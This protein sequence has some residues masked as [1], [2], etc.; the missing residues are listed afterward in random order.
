MGHTAR[1]VRKEFAEFFASPAAL[2]FLGA[3]LVIALFLFFWVE[4][5]FARNIADARALFK[6]L[7]VLLIFLAATLTM[8]T[9]SEERRAGTIETLLTSPVPRVQLVL[10]KFLAGVALVALAL[11]LTF[12]LPV[13][14][15]LLGPLDWGPVIGGYVAALFLAA[16]YIAIGVYMS[17][18]TDNPIVA[19]ILTTMVC[20]VF[21]LLGSPTITGF[22]GHE[23]GGWLMLIGSGARFESV[24]RGVLDL[25]DLY[26]YC[27]I[28][29]MFLT[30]N[31]FSLERVAWAG[32][33][34]SR[35][36]AHWWLVV[37]LVLA[38]FIAANFWLQSIS[39]VRLDITRD[40]MYSLSEATDRYLGQLEEPLLIRGY[41]SAKT[42]PLLAPMVPAIRD[43]LEEYAQI[44]GGNVQVEFVDPHENQALEEEAA[45]KYDIRP[46]PF[47]M[48]SRHQS[49]VVNSYFHVVVAYGDQNETLSFRNLIDVKG[50]SNGELDVVLKDPE[51]AITSAIKKVLT[52]YRAGGNPFDTLTGDV[53]F[54][55]YLSAAD[56]LPPELA[57]LRGDLE[58]VLGELEK[59]SDGRFSVSIVDPDSNGGAL[60]KKLTERYGLRPQLSGLSDQQRFWFSMLMERGGE[61][62]QVPL[63]EDL[64]RESIKRTLV[65]SLK[66]LVPGFLKTIALVTPPAGP[67]ADPYQYLGNALMEN[68]RMTNTDL[69]TGRVPEEVDLLMV[70][71]PGNLNDKQVFAI[72]QFLMQGGT[73][74]LATS[75]NMVQIGADLQVQ[76][77]RSGLEEWL[78]YQGLS[79]D[80]GMVLDPVNTAFPVPVQR[81]IGTVP[82]QEIRRLPYPHFPDLR[83]AQLSQDSIITAG[84]KQ[85]TMNWASAVTI[86]EADASS[87]EATVLLQSSE[88]S[89]VADNI[90]IV[91]DYERFP[92]A[93]FPINEPRGAQVLGVAVQGTFTSFFKDKES[94]LIES[95]DENKSSGSE[96]A[97][98]QT[99]AVAENKGPIITSVIERSPATARLV[100]IGSNTF[101]SDMGLTL[102]S[103]G[104]GT[105]YTKPLEFMQNMID[106]SL[107]DA[108]LLS[109]RG[110]T[111]FSRTLRPMAP[112]EQA[113][114]EYAN[115]VIAIML[116]LFVWIWRRQVNRAALSRFNQLLKDG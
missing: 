115:Y 22:F 60:A 12:P 113:V 14:V 106:W 99:N 93:G 97:S 52:S 8:R 70:V 40:Q 32:N 71:A 69:A 78:A 45:S 56:R 48:A 109:I 91:P 102:T 34:I 116:L 84:L 23:I 46:V 53:Q 82:V 26:F 7:P 62:I 92:E 112:N 42:H 44:S 37:V 1:I 11:A 35:R 51:Y 103:E 29:G 10:G 17:G 79:V 101:A 24:T 88:N 36:H 9:W 108:G 96:Q 54:K 31:L 15:A 74:F 25:R 6:W 2:L 86:K 67:R 100:L 33:P 49:G 76:P 43:L 90:G 77:H 63:P 107:E 94:P 13:T 81:Y 111:Q 4:T 66:R 38:N 19:W 72:D 21:Y 55:G 64:G 28:I 39:S 59:Q 50:G 58:A 3:F 30:L 41:F 73:V 110:R 18:R 61:A 85:L 83:D 80:E 27:A 95:A 65:G 87:R 57:S 114:W 5:F 104:M 75:N 98:A 68:N 89:W 47:Q 20:S 105:M 16:A